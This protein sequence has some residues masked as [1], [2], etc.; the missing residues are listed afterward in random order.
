[1]DKQELERKQAELKAIGEQAH[2]A[3]S[4]VIRNA[5]CAGTMQ[6]DRGRFDM[7]TQRGFI[8][9]RF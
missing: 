7:V 1:M 3:G 6:Q 4:Y 8:L 9:S 2:A 5:C